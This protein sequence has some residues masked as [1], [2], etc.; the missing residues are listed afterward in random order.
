V[1]LSSISGGTDIL[2]CFALGV[3]VL[4]VRRGELQTRSLGYAVDVFDE[5]GRSLV[6]ERGELVCKAPFPSM[7]VRFWND[8]GGTKYREAYFQRFAN[9]WHHGDYVSLTES[10]GM[11]FYGRSDSTLNSCGVRIGTAEIYRMLERI[12]CIEDCVAIEQTWEEDTRIVLFV[13]L[14]PGTLLDERLRDEIRTAI[15]TKTTPRHVPKKIIQ[16]GDIPLTRN[17]KVSELAVKSAVHGIEVKNKH[18][19]AN[20][21]VLAY[22]VGLKE[23]ET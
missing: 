6:G 17:G 15:R 9:T 1:Q 19:L 8:P 13:K 20:P 4:P 3:P 7:P 5:N 23:L 10:G 2:G 22:F 18:A 21:E 16:V 12:D 11:I 14:S